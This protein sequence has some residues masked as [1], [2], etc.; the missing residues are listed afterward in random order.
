VSTFVVKLPTS[1]KINSVMRMHE[2]SGSND[3]YIGECESVSQ[4]HRGA[5]KA[6]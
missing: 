4:S 2:H 3:W 6:S 1:D 5:V